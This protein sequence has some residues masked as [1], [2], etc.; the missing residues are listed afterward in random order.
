MVMS[1][2]QSLKLPSIKTL[3]FTEVPKKIYD[4]NLS[5]LTLPPLKYMICNDTHNNLKII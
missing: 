4:Y 5:N 1:S 2:S 3:G